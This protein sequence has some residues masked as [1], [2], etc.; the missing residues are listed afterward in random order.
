MK[1][2]PYPNYWDILALSVV[3]SVIA[4]LAWNA[5]QMAVP[6]ELGA[7]ITI[8]LDP[9]QLPSYALRTILRM[10][11]ALGV[12]LIFTFTVATLAAKSQRAER[13]IIPCIDILQS[14]PILGFL[15][16]GLAAFVALFPDSLLGPECAAI[17]VIFTSQAWNMTLGFYQTLKTVPEE[18]HE[19]SRM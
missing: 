4:L 2:K 5:K 16:I 14:V 11:I 18:L 19:A 10:L 12:S 8:S 17:F 6:Y 7:P 15:S 9:S 13:L 3:L 1:K